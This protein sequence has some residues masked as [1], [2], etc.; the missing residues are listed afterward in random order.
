MKLLTKKTQERAESEKL[1]VLFI[2]LKETRDLPIA[3]S[4]FLLFVSTCPEG[5]EKNLW[6]RKISQSSISWWKCLEKA[7]TTKIWNNFLSG[8]EDRKAHSNIKHT[9]SPNKINKISCKLWQCQYYNMV[10]PHGCKRN[11]WRKCWVGTTQECYML[12]WTNLGNN[13]L[14]NNS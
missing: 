8:R 10:A 9:H 4:F 13:I 5:V 3:F 7:T 1:R 2:S 6:N 12:F 14:R 11:S